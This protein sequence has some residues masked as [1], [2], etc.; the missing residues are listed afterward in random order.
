MKIKRLLAT[1]LTILGLILIANS[2]IKILGAVTGVNQTAQ[3]ITSVVG[4]AC[5]LVGILIF[6]HTQREPGR[7][8]RDDSFAKS[9]KKH[10][11]KE[12][13]KI[14][15]TIGKI[16]TGLGKE[17]RLVHLGGYAIHVSGTGRIRFYK[18][19]HGDIHLK[20]YEPSHQYE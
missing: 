17:E 7:I 8:I 18:D 11:G 6:F 16:G 20:K 3:N 19:D 15:A 10:R 1:I 12:R 14:E 5:V 13:A 2:Q 9:I 4:L